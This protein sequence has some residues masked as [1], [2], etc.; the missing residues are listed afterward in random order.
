M[1][2]SF[3]FLMRS[4]LIFVERWSIADLAKSVA[5]TPKSVIVKCS[6]NVTFDDRMT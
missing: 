3:F 5:R 4:R 2:S 1:S 6:D